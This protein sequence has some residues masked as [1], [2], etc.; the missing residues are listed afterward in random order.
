[1]TLIDWWHRHFTLEGRDAAWR[2]AYQRKHGRP[3]PGHVPPRPMPAPAAAPVDRPASWPPVPPEVT[4]E[5]VAARYRRGMQVIDSLSP[6][7][8]AM[9][10]E[11]G[12]ILREVAS[13]M[14]AEPPRPRH[15]GMFIVAGEP[16]P[17]GQEIRL[18]ARI[19][20]SFVAWTRIG[21]VKP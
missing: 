17:P 11:D 3:Y 1:M 13:R 4:I 8:L 2:E 7:C 21:S 18:V 10:A 16:I 20:G 15:H 9:L 6:K 19:D 5:E 12:R 14:Q